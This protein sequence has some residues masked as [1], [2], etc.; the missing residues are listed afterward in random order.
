MLQALREEPP[1]NAKCKD[2]F[3]IQSTMITPEKETMPLHDIVCCLLSLYIT[4]AITF[5]QWAAPEKSEES[6]VHQQK[7][8]VTYLPPDG[9]T[10][11]EEDE[12]TLVAQPSQMGPGDAVS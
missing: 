8:R 10:L 7:L 12:N 11:E 4:H 5:L 1:L 9:Q 2:K 6:K 3:L